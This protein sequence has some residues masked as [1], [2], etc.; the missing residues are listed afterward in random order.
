MGQGRFPRKVPAPSRSARLSQVTGWKSAITAAAEMVVS[1]IFCVM[2]VLPNSQAACDFHWLLGVKVKA[3]PRPGGPERQRQSQS[4]P[5]T[6]VVELIIPWQDREEVSKNKGIQG[7]L[8][9]Q[10]EAILSLWYHCWSDSKPPL[11]HV[12]RLFDF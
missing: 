6:Q 8:V 5:K 7:S 11:P 9:Y 4:L 3:S 1:T 2:R 10:V 12:T